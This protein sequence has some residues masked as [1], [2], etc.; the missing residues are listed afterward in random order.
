MK[1]RKN[2]IFKEV[3]SDYYD[4]IYKRKDYRNECQRILN[5]LKKK[6]QQGT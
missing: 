4:L 1:T 2:N 6:S 5:F 3:Y